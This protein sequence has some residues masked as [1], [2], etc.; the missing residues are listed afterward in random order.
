MSFACAEGPRIADVH[1]NTHSTVIGKALI[2]EDI[3]EAEIQLRERGYECDRI[4]HNELLSSAGATYTGKLIKGDYKLL[5][6]STPQDWQARATMKNKQWIHVHQWMKKAL[7]LGMTMRVFGPPG[8]LWKVPNIQEVIKDSNMV[9]TKMR[10]CHFGDKYDAKDS[11]PSGSYMQLAT[12]CKISLH[13][14]QCNCKV[15]IQEHVPAH[16]PFVPD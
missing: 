2:V 13:Q 5:W 16:C 3:R 10:L 9:T 15:P 4:T 14:W 7:M 1:G 12:T 11:K 8:L 6:I